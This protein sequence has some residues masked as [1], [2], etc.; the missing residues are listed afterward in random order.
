VNLSEQS[1]DNPAQAKKNMEKA[2]NL[3][4]EL[5]P[6]TFSAASRFGWRH[7][8]MKSLKGVIHVGA[9][10]GQERDDYG[11]YGLNVLWIELPWV[12]NE[13]KCAFRRDVWPSFHFRH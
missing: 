3:K 12:F 11:S 7:H 2:A 6:A 13:M 1:A 10:T 5:S 9:N 8:L 4:M